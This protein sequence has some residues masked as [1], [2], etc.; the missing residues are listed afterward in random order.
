MNRRR[1]FLTLLGGAAAAWPLAARAQQAAM[2]VIG[3]LNGGSPE[4]LAFRKA[5]F[6]RGL[7]ETGYVENQNVAIEDH[8]ADFRDER[9]P[10]LAADLVRHRVSV[11]FSFGG[12]AASIAA[13]AATATIP[14]VF[15][16]GGDPVALGLVAS[17]NRPGGNVTGVSFLINALGAK[18]LELL[19]DL[20]PAASA[21]GFLVDPTNPN[22]VPETK[23]IQDA[24]AALG[25]R[26][27]IVQASTERAVDAAFATLVQQRADALIV[28]AQAFLTSRQDQLL[29]LTQR[30]ALPA[31]YSRRDFVAAG[32]LMSYSSIVADTDR[33]AGIYAGR[34]LKGERPADLP[35]IQS[36][37]FEL[38]I[39]LKSAKALGLTVPLALQASA[40]ELIE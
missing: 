18:R 30:H 10:E 35:V 3:L 29:A 1:N 31:I 19:R 13:K 12:P 20:V 25:R 23:D 16:T 2:P 6:L 24:A 38:V 17:L 21:I 36:T 4:A 9:L 14:I 28:G 15:A 37:R 27:I 11:I 32:G 39:N 5:E 22:S 33:Q 34:I 26:L 7:K 8:F 40:D